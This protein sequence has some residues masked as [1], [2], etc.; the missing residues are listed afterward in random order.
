M[1]NLY[2]IPLEN[3]RSRDPEW[4]PV[5]PG[6]GQEHMIREVEWDPVHGDIKVDG[7]VVQI[8]LPERPL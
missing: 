7:P 8:K 5:E 3:L 6:Y 2:P 4:E 1:P